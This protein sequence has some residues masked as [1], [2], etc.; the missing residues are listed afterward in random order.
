MSFYTYMILCSDCLYK[1][2]ESSFKDATE[3]KRQHSY[4]HNHGNVECCRVT[5]STSQLYNIC[6]WNNGQ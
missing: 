1:A 5:N 4:S 3:I 6:T 2:V